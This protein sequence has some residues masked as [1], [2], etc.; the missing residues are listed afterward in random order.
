MADAKIIWTEVDE[1]P[2]LATYALLPVIKAFTKGCDI[3][4][5]V[6]RYLAGR[7]HSSPSFRSA[8]CRNSGLPIT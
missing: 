3:D 8:C 1:A 6:Q 5:E 4:V 7:S 2:A